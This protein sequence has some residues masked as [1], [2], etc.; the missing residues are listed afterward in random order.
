M[1][2]IEVTT[3]NDKITAAGQAYAKVR[4]SKILEQFPRAENVHV[5]LDKQRHLFQAE[6]V[7]Q[8]R[9]ERLVGVS[10]HAENL[11]SAID[12]AAARV[13]KQ[14]RANLKKA[15]SKL[16]RNGEKVA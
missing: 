13:E 11:R 8:R 5:I 3:R 14:L 2:T 4:A 10:Q 9:S 16:I 15:N 7:V 1:A 12:T 6:V